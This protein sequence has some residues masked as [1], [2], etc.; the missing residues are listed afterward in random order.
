MAR[1]ASGFRSSLPSY[2]GG[3]RAGIAP[4]FPGLEAPLIA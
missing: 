4:D 3:N 1:G 2:S